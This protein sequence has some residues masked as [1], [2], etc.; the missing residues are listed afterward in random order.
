MLVLIRWR[1]EINTPVSVFA[2]TSTFQLCRFWLACLLIWTLCWQI[3][4]SVGCKTCYWAKK[5]FEPLG[6]F[7]FCTEALVNFFCVV[8]GVEVSP[9]FH[10]HLGTVSNNLGS[11]AYLRSLERQDVHLK[12]DNVNQKTSL[13]SGFNR[14]YQPRPSEYIHFF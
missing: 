4:L 11:F 8:K 13:V 6:F 14:A 5:A 2:S 1:V 3:V 12:L 7:F 9:A 10:V